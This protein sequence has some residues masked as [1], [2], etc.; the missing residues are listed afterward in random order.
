MSRQS[1]KE[2]DERTSEL[3]IS[4]TQVTPNGHLDRLRMKEFHSPPTRPRARPARLGGGDHRFAAK[5]DGATPPRDRRAAL[6]FVGTLPRALGPGDGARHMRLAWLSMPAHLQHR[7][8]TLATAAGCADELRHIIRGRQK[9]SDL[10]ISIF[11]AMTR[12]WR[13][14]PVAFP[15]QPAAVPLSC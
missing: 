5:M 8:A 10:A 14:P 2:N 15:R 13:H 1:E 7:I 6:R 4:R 3:Q 12:A 9:I 11:R